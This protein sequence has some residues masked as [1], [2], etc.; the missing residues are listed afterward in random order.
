LRKGGWVDILFQSDK[1]RKLFEDD[2]ALRKRFGATCAKKIRIRLDDLRDAADLVVMSKLG[3][4]LHPMTGDRTGQLSLDVEHPLRL[5]FVCV[6]EPLPTKEDGSLDWAKV[7]TVRIVG[8][9]D[10]HE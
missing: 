7:R 1:E 5:L 9:E 2:K 3:G 4:R 6:D 10:T 8:V